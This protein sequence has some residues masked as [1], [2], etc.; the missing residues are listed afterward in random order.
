MGPNMSRSDYQIIKVENN[1][2]FLVDLDRGR[3]SVTND[4]EN[5]YAEV[6]KKYPGHRVIYRDS[7]GC[8]DEI[9]LRSNTVMIFGD[10]IECGFVPYTEG[11]I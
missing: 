4:A 7:T 10:R 5:V 2:V 9:V 3:M 1:K 6:T 11:G 8:W